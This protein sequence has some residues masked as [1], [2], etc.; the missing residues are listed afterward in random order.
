MHDVFNLCFTSF[1]LFQ[2]Y[3]SRASYILPS[4]HYKT[5][6]AYTL[7]DTF[8]LPGNVRAFSIFIHH[9]AVLHLAY[10]AINIL[11]IDCHDVCLLEITTLFNSLNRLYL[12]ELTRQIRNISWIIV[13]LMLFPFITFNIMRQMFV[14][15]VEAED[16][17]VFRTYSFSLLSLLILSLEWTNEILRYDQK[18][19]SSIYFVVPAFVHIHSQNYSGVLSAFAICSLSLLKLPMISYRYE[20]RLLINLL[21][22]IYLTRNPTLLL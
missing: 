14:L 19:I 3:L 6:F 16:L 17:V 20:N 12:N 4:T 1:S 7:V 13:R 18:W 5:M 2:N 21:S 10:G 22:S 15:G 8:T 9:I 11:E